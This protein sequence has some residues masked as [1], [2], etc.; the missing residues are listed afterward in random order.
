MAEQRD[1]G[2]ITSAVHSPRLNRNIALAYVRNAFST[3]G[4]A[5][6]F[7]LDDTTHTAEVVAL[8]FA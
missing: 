6:Q 2:K 3:A 8:P 1:A 4:T 7:C 5:L